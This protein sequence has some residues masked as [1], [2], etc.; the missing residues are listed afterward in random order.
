MIYYAK[1]GEGAIWML[2]LYAKTEAAS[3]SPSVLRKIREEI[4][5]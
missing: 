4:D 1:L 2:T 3:I 5:A